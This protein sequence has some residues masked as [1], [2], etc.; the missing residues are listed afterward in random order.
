[1]F[2]IFVSYP[3]WLSPVPLFPSQTLLFELELLEYLLPSSEKPLPFNVVLLFWS[4]PVLV[5]TVSSFVK[6]TTVPGISAPSRIACAESFKPKLRMQKLKQKHFV[7][8]K[9]FI[10]LINNCCVH[11]I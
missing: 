7:I 4:I 10:F 8:S 3:V 6:S 5:P 1:M 9:H 2:K 11:N